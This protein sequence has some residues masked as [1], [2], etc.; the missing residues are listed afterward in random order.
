MD[1]VAA[2]M[3][4]EEGAIFRSS[5]SN[6]GIAFAPDFEAS[7]TKTWYANI[8]RKAQNLDVSRVSHPIGGDGLE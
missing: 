3:H 5:A 2:E 6:H 1:F 4:D 7:V 8:L